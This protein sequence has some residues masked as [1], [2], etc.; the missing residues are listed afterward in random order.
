MNLAATI[1]VGII[2]VIFCLPFTP[3]GVPGNAD[4]SWSSVNY[5]PMTVG[6]LPDPGRRVV[7]DPR[8]HTFKGPVRNIEFEGEGAGVAEETEKV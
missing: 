8:T 3:A 1:W 2:T 5:A 7:A 4:F 6:G